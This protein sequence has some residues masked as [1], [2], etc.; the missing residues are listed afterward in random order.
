[1]M[2][3]SDLSTLVL[4]AFEAMPSAV[5]IDL[6]GTLLAPDATLRP[7]S[8]AAIDALL[9]REIH[10]VIA[11]ARP[12]RAVRTLLGEALLEQVSLVQMNG[13]AVRHAKGTH[14]PLGRFPAEVVRTVA[15]LAASTCRA[16]ESSWRWKVTGSAATY[17]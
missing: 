3:R 8:R 1:M 15:A 14:T 2:A 12:L 4:P 17:R 16:A 6:D 7:R 13:V 9:A 5:V 11:T 10:V